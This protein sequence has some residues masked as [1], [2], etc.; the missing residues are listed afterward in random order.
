MHIDELIHKKPEEKVIFYLRRHIIVFIGGM[1]LISLMA[2][3]PIGAYFGVMKY[4][5]QLFQRELIGPAIMLAASA[6]YFW[7]LLFF[8]ANFVDYYLDAWVVTNDRILNI[9]QKGLFNRTVSELDLLNIQD[10]T[11]EIHGV[12][13][14]F[15]GYGNVQI[16]TAAEQGRFVFE[17]IPKPEEVRKRLLTLV[18]EEQKKIRSVNRKAEEIQALKD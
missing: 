11:S 13:P 2:I 14:F 15:F 5:P 9:E 7:V 4:Y 12:F 3:I 8:F 16:Q 17:Q 6:Y 10:I 1:L 18:E